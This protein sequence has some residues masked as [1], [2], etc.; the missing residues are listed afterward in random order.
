MP[1]GRLRLMRWFLFTTCA[2]IV[3]FV[4]LAFGY[5]LAKHPEHIWLLFRKG[6]LLLVSFGLAA[7]SIADAA[8]FRS[9]YRTAQ[10][11]CLVFCLFVAGAAAVGYTLV[12]VSDIV[13]FEYDSALVDYGSIALFIMMTICS[14]ITAMH[15]RI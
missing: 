9:K 11:W 8:L 13:R 3:P 14:G 10:L 2:S 15:S 1:K 4:F 6:E 7:A 12:A 5:R